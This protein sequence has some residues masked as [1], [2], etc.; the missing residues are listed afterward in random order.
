MSLTHSYYQNLYQATIDRNS[1]AISKILEITSA[2]I[3]KEVLFEFIQC[4]DIGA[5]GIL[6]SHGVDINIT[7]N[8]KVS[9]LM[10]AC[11]SN[12]FE[13]IA[14]LLS[15]DDI[16]LCTPDIVGCIPLQIAAI[17]VAHQDGDERIF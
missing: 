4:G 13:M 9:A 7:N 16:D 12:H 14:Y 10:I 15:R 1:E 17:R 8:S 6:L 2:D 5:V 11:Q 3:Q